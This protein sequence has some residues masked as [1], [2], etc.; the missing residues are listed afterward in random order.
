MPRIL[1]R[2]GHLCQLAI[3]GLCLVVATEVDHIVNNDDHSPANLQAVCAPC[4]RAKTKQEARAGVIR[5]Y[6]RGER[7][8]EPHPGSV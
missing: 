3:P 4:H 5:S 2:D 7:P 8:A 1:R 6:E